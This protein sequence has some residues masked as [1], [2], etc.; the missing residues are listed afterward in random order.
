MS[1]SGLKALPDVCGRDALPD[2]REAFP[3]DQE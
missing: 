1:G 2:V 3:V